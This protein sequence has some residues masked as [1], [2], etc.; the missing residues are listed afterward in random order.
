M[1]WPMIRFDMLQQSD[2]AATFMQGFQN[3]RAFRQ[4]MATDNALAAFAQNP[5]DPQALAALTAANPQVGLGFRREQ[6]QEQF[7][8][9]A[10]EA[11]QQE[12][13][14]RQQQQMVEEGRK[15]VGQAALGILR[16]PEQQRAQAF[17]QQIDVLSQQFPG[18]AQYRGRYSPQLLDAVLA[19]SGLMKEGIDLTSPKYQAIV[20]GGQLQNTNPYANTGM[21]QPAQAPAT[22]P[23]GAIDYL[24]QNPGL[25]A[26]FDAKYGAGAADRVLGGAASGQPGFR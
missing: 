26:E 15:V 2:P 25:K 22:P 7:Q 23:Q 14:A 9:R 11:Q 24:R 16:L 5:D 3:A 13:Q 19:Q 18:L 21:G 4:Q 10:L 1:D 12:A 20:P 8:N 17:D 6:R